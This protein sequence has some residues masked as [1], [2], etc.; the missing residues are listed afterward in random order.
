MPITFIIDRSKNLTTFTMTGEVFFHEFMQIL[1]AYGKQGPTLQEVY[2]ARSI[3]GKRPTTDQ[4]NMLAEYLTKYSDKRASG[5]KTAIVVSESIDFGLSRMLSLLTD[6][7]T[8]YDIEVFRNIAEAYQWL[9]I[10]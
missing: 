2:D 10:S 5:S 1:N 9:E 3:E 6:D 4:M 8:T 7:N